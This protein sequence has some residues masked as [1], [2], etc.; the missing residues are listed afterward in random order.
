MLD[1]ILW[2]GVYKTSFSGEAHTLYGVWI[3]DEIDWGGKGGLL[4]MP[5][6]DGNIDVSRDS[7]GNCRMLVTGGIAA[8]GTY[9]RSTSAHRPSTVKPGFFL[10]N[11]WKTVFATWQ[12]RS[13]LNVTTANSVVYGQDS[14]SLGATVLNLS[15]KGMAD[16]QSAIIIYT[17][18]KN[19]GHANRA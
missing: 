12:G 1:A 9:V 3:V 6:E 15:V 2:G 13:M 5:P 14:D 17:C 19:L 8:D 18:G 7:S 10:I 16:R 11:D 4:L